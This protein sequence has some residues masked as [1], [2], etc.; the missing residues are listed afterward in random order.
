M[1]KNLK[2]VYYRN[3]RTTAEAKANQEGW[4]RPRRRPCNLPNAYDDY[5]PQADRKSWKAKRKT[6]YRPGGRGK[7]HSVVVDYYHT[8]E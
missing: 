8:Y 6:Q 4:G 7:E 3:P 5:Y 1:K 2:Y